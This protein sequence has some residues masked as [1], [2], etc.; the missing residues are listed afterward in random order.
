MPRR[1]KG[2]K[3]LSGNKINLR[4]PWDLAGALRMHPEIDIKA[5]V[6]RAL[7]EAVRRAG[8]PGGQLP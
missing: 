5:V 2:P 3:Y 8:G 6:I 1:R 7:W 4:I